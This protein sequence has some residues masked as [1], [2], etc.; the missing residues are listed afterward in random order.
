VLG[1]HDPLLDGY[2]G[3]VLVPGRGRIPRPPGPVSEDGAADQSFR[4]LGADDLVEDGQQG[5]V[6]VA[7]GGRI[8]RLSGPGGEF[9]A[10]EQRDR[11]LVA[12][13][14][15]R[16]GSSAANGPGAV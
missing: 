8:P 6:L 7:G 1:A 11:M 5:G 14:R 9:V 15:S 10:G 3:G 4:V 13:T 12:E 2:Q 16:A